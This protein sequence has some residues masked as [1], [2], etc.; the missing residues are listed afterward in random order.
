MGGGLAKLSWCEIGEGWVT[1]VGC[2]PI[3]AEPIL[4]DCDGSAGKLTGADMDMEVGKGFSEKLGG[5][6]F[7]EPCGELVPLTIEFNEGEK[8]AR[9][10]GL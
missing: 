8:R 6:R 2:P 3:I 5:G 1:G 10:L 9:E 4:E 7:S